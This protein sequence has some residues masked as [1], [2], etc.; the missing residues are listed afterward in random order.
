M[1]SSEGDKT[2][3]MSWS[4]TN[5]GWGENTEQVQTGVAREQRTKARTPRK[6]ADKALP[7]PGPE[8]AS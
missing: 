7:Q 1:A 2:C 8:E 3:V 5:P 4:W 6:L